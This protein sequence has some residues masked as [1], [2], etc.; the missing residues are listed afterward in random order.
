MTADYQVQA[1]TMIW[2]NAESGDGDGTSLTA[3]RGAKTAHP[4]SWRALP[5]HQPRQ[6]SPR[7]FPKEK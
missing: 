1:S 3:T 6:C 4:I 2:G 5:R 7:D